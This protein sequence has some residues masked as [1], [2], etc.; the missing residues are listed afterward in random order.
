ME[1]KGTHLTASRGGAEFNLDY[2]ATR[3]RQPRVQVMSPIVRTGHG[4]MSDLNPLSGVKQ[5]SNFGAVRSVN[6][7]GHS[8]RARSPLH[9]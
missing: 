9:N 8:G 7:C 6:D 1:R 3:T 5:S 4:P 2:A